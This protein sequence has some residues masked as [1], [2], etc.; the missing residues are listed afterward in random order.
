MVTIDD[1]ESKKE[2]QMLTDDEFLLEDKEKGLK[3]N[4]VNRRK[5]KKVK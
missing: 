2:P 5:G 3:K 4:Q 1:K